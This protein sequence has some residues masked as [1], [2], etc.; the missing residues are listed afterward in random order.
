MI[1]VYIAHPLRGENHQK[2]IEETAMIC[3][4]IYNLFPEIIPISPIH[5]FGFLDG[6]GLEA[7]SKV[8]EYCIDTMKMCEKIWLFGDWRKSEGC[9]IE[10]AVASGCIIPEF[11]IPILDFSE[12]ECKVSLGN[13]KRGS[14]FANL[15]D[16]RKEDPRMELFMNWL[17]DSVYVKNKATKG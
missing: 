8:I 10:N 12:D 14:G 9:S 7:E 15:F 4:K 1:K 17:I 11:Q 16:V 6:Y 3:R 5:M 13:L 2:N